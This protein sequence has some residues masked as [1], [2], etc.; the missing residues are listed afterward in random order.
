[1]TDLDNAREAWE[2]S[3]KRTTTEFEFNQFGGGFVDSAIS[4]VAISRNYIST[5]ESDLARV[6][7]ERNELKHQSILNKAQIKH[8]RHRVQEVEERRAGLTEASEKLEAVIAMRPS[9]NDAKAGW[10]EAD[11]HYL[12]MGRSEYIFRARRYITA[13]EDA[14]EQWEATQ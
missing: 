6:T 4:E 5:L 8:D 10:D 7:R 11:A 14:L 3:V 13:L 9:F 2:I 12:E 1:M